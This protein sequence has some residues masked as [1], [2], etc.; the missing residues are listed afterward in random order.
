MNPLTIAHFFFTFLVS[1]SLTEIFNCVIIPRMFHT[2]KKM[3]K[4]YHG[5][6][7]GFVCEH[8]YT[9]FFYKN[10]F[11]K[12]VEAEIDPNLK[13]VLRTFLRLRVD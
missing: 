6:L 12:N 8:L 10:L 5:K 3:T 1:F 13:N 9:L 11:Y 2:R 7:C 4:P